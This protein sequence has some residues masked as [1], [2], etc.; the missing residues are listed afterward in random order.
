MTTSPTGAR[1]SS[2]FSL[3]ELIIVLAILAVTMATLLPR[4]TMSFAGMQAT[5]ASATLVTSLRYAQVRA[6]AQRQQVQLALVEDEPPG[7]Q[8]L[9]RA[10]P[11]D[12]WRPCPG[13]CGRR[14][15]LPPETTLTIEPVEGSLRGPAAVTFYPNGQADPVRLA[16]QEAQH[17]PRTLLVD[18]A[19]GQVTV[20]QAHD[21]E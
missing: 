11:T 9:V 3:L 16:L 20:Q 5:Q 18:A 21:E 15:P 6:V 7:F 1:R 10:A 4:F 2:G 8:L 13:R 19:T 17:E 12:E 14:H